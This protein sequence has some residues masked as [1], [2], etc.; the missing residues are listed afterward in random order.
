[1]TINAPMERAVFQVATVDEPSAAINPRRLV[2][3]VQTL[4][5]LTPLTR[6]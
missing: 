1:V 6:P 3:T 2:F 5:M 4:T